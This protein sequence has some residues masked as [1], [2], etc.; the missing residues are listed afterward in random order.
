MEHGWMGGHGWMDAWIAS[1]HIHVFFKKGGQFPFFF[2]IKTKGLRSLISQARPTWI[3]V[4]E[5][6]AVGPAPRGRGPRGWRQNKKK[7]EIFSS[8]PLKTGFH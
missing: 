5:K 2:F 6:C 4:A 8:S 7:E 3:S 1:L